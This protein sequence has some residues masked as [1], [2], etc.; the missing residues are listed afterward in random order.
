MWHNYSKNYALAQLQVIIINQSV[1]RK[2]LNFVD[3][4]TST[5]NAKINCP[6]KSWP[7]SSYDSILH[8]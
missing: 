1:G 3:W 4:V 8:N 5:K 6:Q 2:Y 7:Y